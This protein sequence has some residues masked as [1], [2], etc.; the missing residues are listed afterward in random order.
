MRT[1]TLDGSL[2]LMRGKWWV[3]LVTGL[4]W[5]SFSI[6]VFR[7]NFTTVSSISILFGFVVVAVAAN[8]VMLAA[9]TYGARRAFH[10]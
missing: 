4:A 5:V 10:I 7:F 8:E 2:A 6:I 9:F 1:G 3:L